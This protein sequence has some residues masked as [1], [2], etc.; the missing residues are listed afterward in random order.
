[1]DSFVTT[2]RAAR[3]MSFQVSP[4][5]GFL[6]YFLFCLFF[7]FYKS[8][9]LKTLNP[10]SFRRQ[11]LTP[12]YGEVNVVA[13]LLG[14]EL[15]GLRLGA[16]A[17]K[18]EFIYTLPMLTIKEDKGTGVVTSVPSDSPDDYAAF[19]DLKSKAALR[20]KCV[21]CCWVCLFLC[22]FPLFLKFIIGA[23]MASPTRWCCRLSPCRSSTFRA[24]ATSAPLRLATTSRFG[25]SFFVC[26][27]NNTRFLNKKNCRRL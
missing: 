23:G 1:M 2:K 17:M 26:V 19:R 22:F 8:F 4:F 12:T 25:L 18:Y 27:R 14:T 9:F 3:N 5:C 6:F 10:I 7:G 24:T 20:E 15:L 13:E 11:D 16:P 21:L